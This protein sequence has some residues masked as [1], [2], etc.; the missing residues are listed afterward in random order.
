MAT[1][2]KCD[3]C[4]TTEDV[5]T[6]SHEAM[7]INTCLKCEVNAEMAGEAYVAELREAE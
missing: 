1:I 7:V 2:I 4:G 5:D 6:Y 3:Y